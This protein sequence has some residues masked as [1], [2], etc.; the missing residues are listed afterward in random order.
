MKQFLFLTAAVMIG[1]TAAIAAPFWGVMLYYALATLRPQ[2]L[3]AWALADM[4]TVRWSLLAGGIAIGAFL[5]HLPT[6]INTARTNKVLGLLLIYALLITLSV[7]TA[8][9]PKIA[10]FWLE[11]Y[12]KVIAIAVI[13]SLVVQQ[14]WQVRAL[15]IMITL[16]IGYIALEINHLYFTQGGRLDI[17]HEGYG[18]LDNNGAGALIALGIP[19]AYFLATSRAGEWVKPRRVVGVVLGLLMLHAVMMTYSRGAML[20]AA[21]GIGW[22]LFHHRP[23]KQAAAAACAMVFVVGVMAGPEIRDRFT[24]TAEF[25][26]DASAQSRFESWGAAWRMAWE[27]PLLG[28]GIRNSNTY[29]ENFG[30]DMAGRTIHNQYLQMAAD[31]GIPAALVYTVM[32]LL[33]LWGVHLA[34]RKLLQFHGD[35]ADELD[36]E[37]HARL[38]EAAALTLAI[39]AAVMMFMFSA[40]FL[41][42]ELVELPWLLIVLAGVTP[43]AVHYFLDAFEDE[44]LPVAET[45]PGD[46]SLDPPPPVVSPAQPML[47]EERHA[48]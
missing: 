9:N 6:I 29:S 24:S 45:Q 22:I 23:R 10:Q 28:K 39:Q 18:G 15:A 46:T 30:A 35:N 37:Q 44:T 7:L 1:G 27:H 43:M 38:D 32:L 11:E 42:V 12:A 40:I 4:P 31:S 25:Q 13:A 21:V 20:A 47:E 34:R 5:I 16:T 3:W 17:L 33:G 19:F 14:L 36:D 26:T 48:A 8:F 2:N 41:S